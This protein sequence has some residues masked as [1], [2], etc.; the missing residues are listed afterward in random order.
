MTKRVLVVLCCFALL[1]GSFGL[2]SAIATSAK[3]RTAAYPRVST[4]STWYGF[5]R[6]NALTRWGEAAAIAATGFP[7]WAGVTDVVVACGD[8]RALADPLAASGLCWL[9]DAPLLLTSA[10]FLPNETRTAI[11]AIKAANPDVTVHVVGGPGSVPAVQLG[12]VQSLVGTS[13]VERLPYGNR[14]QVA[15]AI[16][17]RMHEEAGARGKSLATTAFL[18][19]GADPGTFWDA[20]ALSS[21]SARQGIPLLLTGPTALD[22]YTAAELDELL[23]AS[24]VIG[25]G[26]L[27]AS[28]TSKITAVDPFATVSRWSGANRY[29]TAA[30]IAKGAI[31]RG[32]LSGAEAGFAAKLPD[33]VCGGAFM[34]ARRG[35]VLFYVDPTR[36]P[37]WS[38]KAVLDT[39]AQTQAWGFGGTGSLT[40]QT[41]TDLRMLMDPAVPMVHRLG[42]YSAKVSVAKTPRGPYPFQTATARVT[43][44]DQFG[45]VAG[46]PKVYATWT[47]WSR[48]YNGNPPKPGVARPVTGSSSA[49][50]PPAGILD[51][52]LSDLYPAP[53]H[54]NYCKVKIVSGKKVMYKTMSFHWLK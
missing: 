52:S 7:Q 38:A 32:W 31:G 14:Y 42:G 1:F 8:D 44:T 21:V 23:P 11:S 22:K 48:T 20:L 27:P 51:T 12:A 24:V 53:G 40:P 35:G 41:V 28:M 54:T 34:G 43:T 45:F 17:H 19:N 13:T 36:V 18:A 5:H 3:T 10:G 30:A 26:T 49:A 4:G 16:A 50:V 15:A 39:A 46:G 25:G 33:A 37:Y 47:Y 9:Y 6:I 29:A 2:P